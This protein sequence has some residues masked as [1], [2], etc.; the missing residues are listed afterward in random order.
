MFKT[1]ISSVDPLHN[2]VENSGQAEQ[3]LFDRWASWGPS[4][5]GGKSKTYEALQGPLSTKLCGTE[6]ANL[7]LTL[8][9]P[10]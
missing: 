5:K 3:G 1:D 2:T 6:D 7:P 9:T 10:L 4:H 8:H